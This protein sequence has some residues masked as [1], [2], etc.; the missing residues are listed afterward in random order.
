MF[1]SRSLSEKPTKIY[2]PEGCIAILNASSENIG[3]RRL[4]TIM[5]KVLEEISYDASEL[6]GEKVKIDKNYVVD[7]VEEIA[8]DT[9]LSKF[10][11]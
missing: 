7:K 9:D 3:A 5:E 4:Y 6:K 10:I 2:N 11:L 8:Q 1:I